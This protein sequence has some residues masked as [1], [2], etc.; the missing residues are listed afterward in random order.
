MT[1]SI[2]RLVDEMTAPDGWVIRWDMRANP[3][4]YDEFDADGV[5]AFTVSGEMTVLDLLHAVERFVAEHDGQ[6]RLL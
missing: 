3:R 4:H 1:V 2:K 6:L 5:M